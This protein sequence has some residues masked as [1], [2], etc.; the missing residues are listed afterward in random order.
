[1]HWSLTVQGPGNKQWILQT[2]LLLLSY[3]LFC[4]ENRN[5]DRLISTVGKTV[6]YR[7]LLEEMGA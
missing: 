2:Q 1:M 4:R 7:E 5:E 3:L 6:H